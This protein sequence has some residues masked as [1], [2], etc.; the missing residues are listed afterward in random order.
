V[1][2]LGAQLRRYGIDDP[3]GL[4]LVDAMRDRYSGLWKR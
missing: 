1:T 3:V 4:R 2:D